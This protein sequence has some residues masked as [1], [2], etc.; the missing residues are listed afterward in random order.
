[1]TISTAHAATFG[2]WVSDAKGETRIFVSQMTVSKVTR[3]IRALFT[4]NT[5]SLVAQL[6][7]NQDHTVMADWD[8]FA[9]VGPVTMV[10][11]RKG[12]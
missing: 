6:L 11:V 10:V 3:S 2:T 7:L 5:K 8:W 1:M 4:I 9:Q 12:R